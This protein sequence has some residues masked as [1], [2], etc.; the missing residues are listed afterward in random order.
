MMSSNVSEFSFIGRERPKRIFWITDICVK[1]CLRKNE[2][3]IIRELKFKV[4]NNKLS[5]RRGPF[6]S[7]EKKFG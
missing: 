5:S 1:S 4:L 2:A 7:A 6:R 3:K